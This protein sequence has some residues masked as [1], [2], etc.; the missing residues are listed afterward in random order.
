MPRM[1]QATGDVNLPYSHWTFRHLEGLDFVT[2]SR[3]SHGMGIRGSNLFLEERQLSSWFIQQRIQLTQSPR[4]TPVSLGTQSRW[5]AKG[6]TEAAEIYFWSDLLFFFLFNAL[7]KLMTFNFLP[8]A[9]KVGFPNFKALES[10]MWNH[11]NLYNQT[12]AD[13][14]S[15]LLFSSLIYLIAFGLWLKWN[16]FSD[17]QDVFPKKLDFLHSC[18]I[19]NDN[20][21]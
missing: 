21:K 14:C 5:E 1:L 6:V 19:W 3:L 11:K 12:P 13:S 9:F 15:Y 4:L 17:T 16:L 18:C 10:N 7:P 2:A 20:I 8:P